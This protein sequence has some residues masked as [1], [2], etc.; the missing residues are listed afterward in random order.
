MILTINNPTFM[1]LLFK[2]Y[3]LWK[4]IKYIYDQQNSDP[5]CILT[6]NLGQI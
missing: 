4:I 2:F 5:F 1:I 3:M 6:E